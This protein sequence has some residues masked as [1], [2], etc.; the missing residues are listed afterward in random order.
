MA[1]LVK[2]FVSFDRDIERIRYQVSISAMREVELFH[3]VTLAS[4]VQLQD[5][6]AYR[7]RQLIMASAC[8]NFRTA[9][10]Q[11]LTRTSGLSTH[12]RAAKLLRRLWTA[13]GR[14][15]G[16]AWEPS[17]YNPDDAIRAARLLQCGNFQQ[18]S[19]G[20]GT[21]TA[22]VE[23]R[24]VRNVLVH[25]SPSAWR[26]YLELFGNRRQ[27]VSPLSYALNVDPTTGLSRL[28]L[29]MRDLRIAFAAAVQ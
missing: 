17:W 27:V 9:G 16:A 18:I 23:L 2:I 6:W 22:P 29:W 21:S 11:V 13:G 25:D 3:A 8:G 12:E 14:T 5:R 15:L 26:K 7:V 24:A 1:S 20:L 28:S 10:G 4:C 19:L